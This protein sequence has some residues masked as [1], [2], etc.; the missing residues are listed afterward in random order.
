MIFFT[1]ELSS[2]GREMGKCRGNRA[3]DLGSV[4]YV[5]CTVFRTCFY[6]SSKCLHFRLE[7]PCNM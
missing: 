2:A 7:G 4:L 5:V 3:T 6:F 1:L